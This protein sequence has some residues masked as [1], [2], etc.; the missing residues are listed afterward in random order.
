[1]CEA[2]IYERSLIIVLPLTDPDKIKLK[3]FTDHEIDL[4]KNLAL[5]VLHR[6]TCLKEGFAF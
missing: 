2:V 4:I 3:K 5:Q 1:M 6:Q